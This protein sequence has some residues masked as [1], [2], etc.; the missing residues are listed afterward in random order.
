VTV[1]A[2]SGDHALCARRG[3]LVMAIGA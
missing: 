1:A 3:A 2:G